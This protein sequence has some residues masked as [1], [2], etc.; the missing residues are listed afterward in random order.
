MYFS[1]IFHLK[2][3]KADIKYSV[4]ASSRPSWLSWMKRDPLRKW[5]SIGILIDLLYTGQIFSLALFFGSQD[6]KTTIIPQAGSTVFVSI[7]WLGPSDQSRRVFA[8]IIK[9]G[10][11]DS[12]FICT[13]W[14]Q[15]AYQIDLNTDNHPGFLAMTYWVGISRLVS[16]PLLRQTV[17]DTK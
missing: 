16:G 14:L 13:V 2:K 4:Y 10:K 5:I 6:G 15:E 1:F 8:P 7:V 12:V 17:S 3:H 11:N 9:A